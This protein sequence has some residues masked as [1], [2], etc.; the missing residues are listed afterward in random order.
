MSPKGVTSV[1]VSRRRGCGVKTSFRASE[2]RGTPT[3]WFLSAFFG[4][5]TLKLISATPLFETPRTFSRATLGRR[6]T[7]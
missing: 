5:C 3:R 2:G 1:D 7:P 4:I 6:K